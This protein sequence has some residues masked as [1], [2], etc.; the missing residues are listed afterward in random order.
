MR[1]EARNAPQQPSRVE[2]C[3]LTTH[4]QVAAP[5]PRTYPFPVQRGVPACLSGSKDGVG[6]QPGDSQ[7]ELPV[8]KNTLEKHGKRPSAGISPSAGPGDQRIPDVHSS[9]FIS[10]LQFNLKMLKIQTK[11]RAC[12]C[13]VPGWRR[14][15]LD[16]HRRTSR[17]C[18]SPAS[19]PAPRNTSPNQGVS[20]NLEF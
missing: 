17:R 7:S 18:R 9:R 11:S 6:R 8:R 4:R 15:T 20:L 10:E 2:P 5:N 12:S 16:V 13:A 3:A 19:R 14:E 1:S